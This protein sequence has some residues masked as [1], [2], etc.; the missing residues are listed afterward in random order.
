MN[1]DRFKT[2]SNSQKWKVNLVFRLGF[3]RDREG[4]CFWK[5]TDGGYMWC[6]HHLP[7]FTDLWLYILF[8]WYLA[9]IFKVIEY[10]EVNNIVGSPWTHRQDPPCVICCPF[11]YFF[12]P[13]EKYICPKDLIIHAMQ[14]KI[15]DHFLIA[16]HNSQHLTRHYWWGCTFDVFSV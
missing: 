1:N 2:R 12:F 5:N 3:A 7:C 9:D 14:W 8:Y 16:S 6:I 15:S 4:M 10:Q 11:L 13:N